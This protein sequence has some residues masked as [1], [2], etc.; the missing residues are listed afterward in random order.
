MR[1]PIGDDVGVS[2]IDDGDHGAANAVRFAVGHVQ[3]GRE[4]HA[5]AQS[6]LSARQNVGVHNFRGNFSTGLVVAN[7]QAAFGQVACQV[8]AVRCDDMTQVL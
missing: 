6:A 5:W 7:H 8:A 1:V 4:V 3:R 2:N